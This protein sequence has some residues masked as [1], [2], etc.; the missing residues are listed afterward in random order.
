MIWLLFNYTAYYNYDDDNE[1]SYADY[2]TGNQY[3]I[4]FVEY[5]AVNLHI[6]FNVGFA[7]D[8]GIVSIDWVILLFRARSIVYENLRLYI[9]DDTL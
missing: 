4:G 3:G 9:W 2:I 6:E 5:W 7:N 8:T 1:N